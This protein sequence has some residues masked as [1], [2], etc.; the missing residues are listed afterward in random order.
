MSIVLEGWDCPVCRIFNGEI[1]EKRSDCRSCGLAFVR[2]RLFAVGD[3]V[4]AVD[5]QSKGWLGSVKEL[6]DKA[7]LGVWM[8]G[9]DFWGIRERYVR[10]D[11]LLKVENVPQRSR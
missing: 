11:F 4:V 10:E 1:K 2:P 3:V 5:G 7:P 9:V 8:Y 6:G